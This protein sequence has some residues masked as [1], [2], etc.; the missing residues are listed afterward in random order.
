MLNHF[1]GSMTFKIC[2][3]ILEKHLSWIRESNTQKEISKKHIS[4]CQNQRNKYIH[5]N[6]E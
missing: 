6:N 4:L 1:F 3:G 5:E 2:E